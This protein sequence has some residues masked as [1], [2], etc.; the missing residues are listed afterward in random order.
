MFLDSNYYP[1][2]ADEP[3][4][5]LMTTSLP[6]DRIS[7]FSNLDDDE[8]WLMSVDDKPNDDLNDWLDGAMKDFD[9]S[10]LKRQK[11]KLQQQNNN[12][13]FR[14]CCV[15][16]I[17]MKSCFSLKISQKCLSNLFQKKSKK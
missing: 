9:K 17:F 8:T 4:G 13:R 11:R 14:Q 5:T 3:D 12:C 6:P 2:M 15:L 1:E 10:G 16:P 7:L